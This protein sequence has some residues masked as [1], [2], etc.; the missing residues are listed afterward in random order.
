LKAVI[1][2]GGQGTRLRPLTCNIPKAIVPILNKPFL[3]HLLNYLRR[4][5]VNQVILA[6]GYNPEPIKQCLASQSKLGIDIEYVIEDNPLG[7]AGAVKN[8]EQYLDDTFIVFNGDI[9]TEIDLSEMIDLHKKLKPEASIALTPVDN[10]SIYGVVETGADNMVKR[11]VE[12]PPPEKVTTNMINAGIYILEP[13]VLKRIPESEFFMFERQVFPEMLQEKLPILGYK[14]DA[15]WIDIGTPEKYLKVNHYM[16]NQIPG[17]MII[18][19][20][21]S[22]IS[23]NAKITGPVSIGKNCRIAEGTMVKDSTVIGPGCS[24][25]NNTIIEGSIIWSGVHI[26]ANSSLKN[27]IIGSNCIIGPSNILENCVIGDNIAVKA[28]SRIEPGSKI[29]PEGCTEE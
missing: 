11:F 17:N 27:C 29:W 23:S 13:E 2:V 9:I 28:H 16:L 25:A 14:S 19:D 4:H 6:M 8:T 5:G 10:P 24:I 18:L 15:Y 12:K 26:A 3:V 7:T 21:E 22:D 20:D 1:L